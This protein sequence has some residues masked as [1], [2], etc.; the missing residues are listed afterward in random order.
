[1]T[2][3]ILGIAVSVAAA[4]IAVTAAGPSE[5]PAGDNE[6]GQRLIQMLKERDAAVRAL[7]RSTEGPLSPADMKRMKAIVGEAFDY[8]ELSRESLKKYWPERTPEERKEF[9]DLY[10]RLIERSYANP[11]LYRKVEDIVYV[12]A[13]VVGEQARVRTTVH[14]KGEESE[15]VYALHRAGGEW[16]ITDMTID[17]VSVVR[18]N[19]QNFYREIARSSYAV[20]VS[21]IRKKL[22]EEPSGSDKTS[23][24]V[25]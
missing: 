14:Y 5:T 1:M 2:M 20:L 3:R 19:R 16:L 18:N 23:A 13:D 7:A 21:K 4:T 15:I 24:K 22:A 25:Y 17:D 11:K 9:A 8:D 10:R 12:G 6:V